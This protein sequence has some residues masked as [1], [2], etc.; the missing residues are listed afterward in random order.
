MIAAEH[1]GRADSSLCCHMGSHPRRPPSLVAMLRD[2]NLPANDSKVKHE[3]T[4]ARPTRRL[5]LDSLFSRCGMALD[6]NHKRPNHR[7]SPRWSR[8]TE[9]AIE[10]A[11]ESDH[12]QRL[13]DLEVA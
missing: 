1:F 7:Q 11:S 2:T 12:H 10:S 8:A 6:E 3:T 13:A 9:S 4:S 5:V